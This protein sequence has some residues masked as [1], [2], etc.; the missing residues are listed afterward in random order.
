MFVAS[1]LAIYQSDLKRL[2]A[3][4]SVAQMGYIVLGIGMANTAGLTAGVLHLFNHGITKGAIFLLL[5]L[6][7]FAQGS[8][9]LSHLKGLGKTMPLTSLGLVICGL[10]LIGMPGTS[11]F[12][13]KWYLIMAALELG[14]WWL[15]FLI[16]SSSLL[17][18]AYVWKF[19][20][21]AYFQSPDAPAKA[22]RAL[23]LTM[24]L[25]ALL[26]TA[27]TLYFGLDTRFTIG[28]ATGAV[29]ALIGGPP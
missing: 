6:V 14:H 17:A 3:F 18:I 28:S 25:P 4:S 19:V 21:V 29:A 9:R 8:T 2:F 12:I 1:F 10:S 26:L 24:V 22:G 5:G 16:V 20:E 23:P 15:V 11:G 7:A 13:S 27:S